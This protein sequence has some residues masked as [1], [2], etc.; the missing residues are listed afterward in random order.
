VFD[1]VL[2]VS[3]L[4]SICAAC[5]DGGNQPTV[6]AG[7]E[8]SKVAILAVA[9]ATGGEGHG[10][11]DNVITCPR[12]GVINYLN[13]PLGRSATFTGCD[14]GDGVIVDGDAEIRWVT[15]G[16]R[17]SITRIDVAGTLRAH[18][19]AGSESTIT[20][21]SITGVAF[22]APFEPSLSNLIFDP[23][24]I[25]SSGTAVRL[26]DRAAAGVV[27]PTAA[28]PID[29]IANP[30]A[31]LEAITPVD[32]KTIAYGNG[33]RLARLLFEETLESQRGEHEHVLPCGRVR[34][35]PEP[36]TQ[37]VRLENTWTACDLGGGITVSGTFTQRWTAF[38]NR[39]GVM[40]MTIDGQMILGGNVPQI[41]LT[42]LEWSAASTGTLA[43]LRISGRLIAG[44]SQRP[45]TFDLVVDD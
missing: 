20:A 27:F 1:R 41:T 22:T 29:A 44:E 9:V 13:T 32:A 43:L 2:R 19:P 25:T 5:S 35:V 37:L 36:A 4:A 30:S 7:L 24:R 45:F 38:E 23:I 3:C 15:G 11:F 6:T 18:G 33:M 21:L 10:F 12:R 42:R 34:V 16:D 28:R 8:D 17:S 14:A 26:D 39:S 31:S 40:S